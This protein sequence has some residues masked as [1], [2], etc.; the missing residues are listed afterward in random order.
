MQILATCLSVT[1]KSCGKL[2]SS[3]PIIFD[4][5]LRVIP[6]EF[7]VAYFSLSY[8]ESDN[9]IFAM[10][11]SVISTNTTI[12]Y[13]T[14]FIERVYNAFIVPFENSKIISSIMKYIVVF[15]AHSR[16]PVK[17]ICWIAFGSGSRVCFDLL[18]PPFVFL[19]Y[20]VNQARKQLSSHLF[21]L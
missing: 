3:V 9:Y 2:V 12:K 11:Y 15:P 19:W 13:Q 6:V 4:D 8:S 10:W 17:L 16:F 14:K 18:L 5:N 21:D 1:N 20:M 7:F